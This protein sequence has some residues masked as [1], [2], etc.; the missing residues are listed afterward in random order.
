VKVKVKRVSTV[1]LKK[2]Y[3]ESEA[4]WERQ[5]KRPLSERIHEKL[6]GLK[7]YQEEIKNVMTHRKHA[8]EQTEEAAKSL[9]LFEA[10]GNTVLL[11]AV[12]FHRGLAEQNLQEAE[13]AIDAAHAIVDKYNLD[14][15]MK[16]SGI[17][18]R[19]RHVP[20]YSGAT[21]RPHKSPRTGASRRTGRKG[22][23]RYAS[24]YTNKKRFAVTG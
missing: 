18:Q 22:R 23:R 14:K 10:T 6:E 1:P 12:E 7:L 4:E 15:S 3:I 19:G 17:L 5:K 24:R 9:K 2:A 20:H 21:L 8:E 13:M 11:K 16:Q